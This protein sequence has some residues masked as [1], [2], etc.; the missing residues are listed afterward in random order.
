M[1]PLD[2]L[3]CYTMVKLTEKQKDTLWG[4][5]A[6]CLFV[7]FGTAL[8]VAIAGGIAGSAPMLGAGLGIVC[9]ITVGMMIYREHNLMS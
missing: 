8:G 7:T 9:V 1:D 3:I 4:I 2:T 6:V 5:A